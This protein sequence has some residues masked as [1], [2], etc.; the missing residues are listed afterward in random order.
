MIIF[1]RLSEVCKAKGCGKSSL[2]E[3]IQAGLFT[4]PVKTG[5]RA[6]AWPSYEVQALNKARLAGKTEAEV[7][8]IVICLVAA[9]RAIDDSA[10]AAVL[11]NSNHDAPIEGD[12]LGDGARLFTKT[13][14]PQI[15]KRQGVKEDGLEAD[16]GQP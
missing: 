16:G 3:E 5:K 9:R 7:K 15:R 4:P 6:S 2:Y 10:I 11:N 12:N 13:R 1:L 8:Q 14:K